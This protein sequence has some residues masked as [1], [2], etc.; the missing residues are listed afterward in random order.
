MRKLASVRL[1]KE[2]LP[3]ENADRLELAIIDGWQVVVLKNEY[4]AGDIC[5]YFEV[6]S[7][8]PLKPQFEFLRKGC[9]KRMG[10]LEGLRLRTIKLRGQISQGLAIKPDKLEELNNVKLELGQDVSELLGVIKYEPPIPAQLSGNAKGNFP[11]FIPKTDEERVQNLNYSQLRDLNEV[12]Y[13]TEKLDGTSST[14]YVRDS[15]FGVCS[16]NLELKLDEQNTYW[17]VAHDLNLEEK[18]KGLNK[19]IAIQGEIIGEG[20]QK[21]VYGVKGH[22][23]YVFNVFDIDKYCR[24]SLE[25]MQT[26]IKELDLEMV[27]LLTNSFHLPDNQKE[28]LDYAVAPSFFNPNVKRE[29]VVLRTLDNKL[30]F[31]VISNDYLLKED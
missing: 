24:F 17:Q 31:K 23:L 6:D 28:L 19:N 16:R 29:G 21:N 18:L 4:E 3:I 8:L 22:K 1:V 9:Y 2:V 27:P 26:L 10:D 5:I 30:S 20:I 14:F 12:F 11:G 13:V 15:E 25:E 7:F